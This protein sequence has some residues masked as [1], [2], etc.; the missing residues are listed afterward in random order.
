MHFHRSF[1]TIQRF[2]YDI[3]RKGKLVAMVSTVIFT[4]Y[5]D[6]VA[7]RD[8][9]TCKNCNVGLITCRK[10]MIVF[11]FIAMRQLIILLCRSKLSVS[12]ESILKE[13]PGDRKTGFAP[14]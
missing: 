2:E 4:H 14:A 10:Y 11:S 3:S 12:T 13:S 8:S 1:E 9:F 5:R 6:E 7:S